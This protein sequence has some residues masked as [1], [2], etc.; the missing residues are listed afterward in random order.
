MPSASLRSTRSLAVIAALAIVLATLAAGLV[1]ARPADAAQPAPGHTGLVPSTPRTNTPRISTGEIWDIE[2]VGQRVFIA[3]TFTSLRN[4]TAT[5]TTSVS[6]RFLASYNWST[7]LI[8]TSFR[9]TFGGG[10]V[11]AVEASPD[12]TK[13]YVAGS[14]NT[15]NGVTK[16]KIASLNLTTGAPVA[17]FTAN[18]GAQATALAATNTT[19][20]VGGNFK[21]VNGA[22][23]VGLVAVNGTTGAVVPGFVNNMS[24]GIGVNGLL[25]VQQLKLTHDDTK[26]LVVHTGR[27]IADQDRYGVGL[28]STQTNQLLPWRTRLWDDNLQFV[29]GI[30]R[31]YAGDIAPNDQY[32]VVGSGSGGDRPPINDTA[33]AFPVAGNDNVQPLWVSRHFDSVYSV[34]I[35]E[36]AVYVGGHF[37]FQESPT[38]PDPWPGLDN[39]GYGTGQGLAGYGLGDAVVRRDHIG[40]LNPADGKALEW[41]PGSNS[42]EGNKAM[43]A[44]PRGL[45]VG[46]DGQYQGG[47]LT[48]RVAFYDFNTA[49]AATA[50][51]TTIT[52]P[53]E[54]RVVQSGVQFTIQGRATATGGQVRRVQVE[55]QDR[56]TKQYLQDNLTTWGGVNNIYASLD[57]PNAASTAWSLPVTITGNRELQVMAKTFAVGGSSD[58]SK[59][60]KKIESFGIDDQTPT[61]SINGPSGSV[62]A[63]TTFTATGTAS[64]DKGVNA[65]TF[66]FRNAS[67][68]YLQE[69]GSVSSNFNTFRGTPDVVGATSATWQYEVTLPHEGEWRMSATAIDNAGQSDLRS[70]TRDWLITSTGVAPAVAINAPAPMT[71]PTAAPTYT[72]TPGGR[73]TFSGTAN[74][75]DDLVS[76]EISLRNNTTREQLASDGTWGTDVVQD[77]YRLNTNSINAT[78]Y[79][80][81]YQTPFNLTPGQYSFS[82][83]ATDEIG[84]TTSSTNQ[85]RLTI[86]AQVAGDAFPDGRLTFTGTDSSIETLHL[87]LTGTATDDKGVAA[88]R[89]A[90]EDQ[91]TGR[92]VQPNGTMAAAFATLPA[93]LGTPDGTTTSFTLAVD[94]PTKGEF[95]V[96][97]FAIDTAGQQ[98]TS[99]SGATARYLVYPGDLDPWL[100]E[101]LASPTEGTA[102]TEARIF[103]SGRAEDDTAMGSVQ[104]AIVNS[105]GQY[106]SSSGSFTS[107]SESWRSAFLNSP[108]TPGSNYSYTTPVIPSGAYSVRTRAVDAYGQVQP[109]PRQVNV[110]VSAPAGNV[111]PTASFTVSCA[112]NVCGFD[113]RGSTDENAPTLTYSWNFGNGRTGSGPVPSHTYTSANTYTVTLT[114]RDEYGLTGTTTRTVTITEPAGNVA[115]TPVINP[116]ACAGLVCNISGVGSADPNTGDTFSYLWSFGDGTSSTSSASSHTFPAAGTYTVTLTVTDGWGRSASTTRTVTV[117]A[118]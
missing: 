14:F 113:G 92:Y 7:G 61:T 95:A 1:A 16:R 109:I 98:D 115:P 18:A 42:F 8:D 103:V 22:A 49:P 37:G 60:I 56:N 24:G 25:T 88:V 107:T 50:V 54:G 43:E 63:S 93:S 116:P 99:T 20:Y 68:Q 79:N 64:D 114:V 70:A 51:D 96:T 110:T 36:R 33:I 12:G 31:V 47:K 17:G 81:S 46:G 87:D 15:V 27:K 62:L 11:N 77:W 100:N 52:T 71:P 91:D 9:P 111:A 97:A 32:F 21:T 94:L 78:S 38:A 90:L 58:P 67:N 102:F 101:N 55:I 44:T 65:L 86:N 30:Q 4:N 41:N 72:V 75:T 84:L 3:G 10:G 53:I 34:A 112:Q 39:V 118:T 73:L 19:L 80:W 13:L 117:T 83:R 28:I 23:R 105:A 6:Q 104:V 66:W 69:D 59:A 108:G 106:M 5:N 2:V 57:T 45:F 26:L 82:V 89:I 48:G 29:G 85:G 35:T 40:A 76:V 74:D